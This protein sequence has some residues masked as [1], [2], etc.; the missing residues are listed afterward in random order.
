MVL[1]QLTGKINDLG[2]LEVELPLGLPV[3]EVNVTLEVPTMVDDTKP[4]TDE[5]LAA[6]L[7]TEPK[8][9]TEIALAIQAGLIGDGWSHMTLSGEEWVEQQRNKDR[10]RNKW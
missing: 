2:K 9:G 1:I 3:G 7:K 5:E 8:T 10:E 4:W 6:L